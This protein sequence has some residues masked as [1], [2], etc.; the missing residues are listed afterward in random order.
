MSDLS[1]IIAIFLTPLLISLVFHKDIDSSSSIVIG[2]FVIKGF[3]LTYLIW[4]AINS[5]IY[6][7][8][9]GFSSMIFLVIQL[10]ME[11]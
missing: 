3:S 1:T 8:Y 4:F 10:F 11:V 7:L 2:S 9:H 5:I 6:C